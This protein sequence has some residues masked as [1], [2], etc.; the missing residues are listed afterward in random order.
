MKKINNYVL[1][2]LHALFLFVYHLCYE[3]FHFFF[4]FE[5]IKLT[6]WCVLI[7]PI[8]TNSKLLLFS[9]HW[10]SLCSRFWHLLPTNNCHFLLSS[11]LCFAFTLWQIHRFKKIF[12]NVKFEWKMSQAYFLIA[13]CFYS[14][15]RCNLD[16]RYFFW[17]LVNLK[18]RW[19]FPKQRER[20]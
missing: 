6:L 15:Q 4:L 8:I 19:R 10:S 9:L 11:P 3:S 1:W 16:L 14:K 12:E 20:N 7:A 18:R 2:F 17:P 5:W 13:E